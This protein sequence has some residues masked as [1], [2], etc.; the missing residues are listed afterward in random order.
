MMVRILVALLILTAAIAGLAV[1]ARAQQEPP[2]TEEAVPEPPAAIPEPPAA[3]P[4]P[5]ACPPDRILVKVKPGAD[6]AVVIGRYG[7]TIIQTIL[8]IDVQVVN[9]PGGTGQQAIDA[10]NA[11]PDV[12]YA[13][14]DGV[15]RISNGGSGTGCQP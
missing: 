12:Q 3:A 5:A 15:V 8:G 2:P 7:G 4:S 14:P 13:E 6:P 10:L 1:T 11:D 9:V